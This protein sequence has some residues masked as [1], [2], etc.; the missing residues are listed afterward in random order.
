MNLLPQRVRATPA[1]IRA[2]PFLVFVVLT[3]LQPYAGAT[4]SYWIYLLKT[5][6]VGVMLFQ[7]R[8]LISEM[9][10]AVSW[11]AIA[12]GIAVFAV[13]VKLEDAWRSVG[14]PGS[15]AWKITGPR[16]NPIES[17]GEGSG[18]AF[19]FLL[20]RCVGSVL[21]VPPMEEV[22]FRSLAYRYLIRPDFQSVPLGQFAWMPFL[23]TSLLFGF[24]HRE[25][26]AGILCGLAYQGLVCWKKRLGDAIT[27]HAITNALLAW[28][29]IGRGHWQFW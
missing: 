15:I 6:F 11:E 26:A 16:W 17:F 20:V 27:A 9:R 28:W 21:V 2:F 14:L 19:L 29:V 7:A 1:L 13:W 4:G 22:F 3:A 23:V 5:V 18:L 12:I 8:G 24:E 25:W 10:W